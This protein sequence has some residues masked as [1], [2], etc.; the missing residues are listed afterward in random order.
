LKEFYEC[1]KGEVG[2]T[3]DDCVDEKIQFEIVEKPEMNR[4]DREWERKK[5][6][7]KM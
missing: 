5:G 7:V 2:S 3:V 4:A 1:V 6:D